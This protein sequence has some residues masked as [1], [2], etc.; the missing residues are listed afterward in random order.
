MRDYLVAQGAHKQPHSGRSLLVHLEGVH[1]IL[2]A[3]KSEPDVCRAGMFHSVYGTA[4]YKLQLLDRE[5]RAEVRD[6]IGARAEEVAWTFCKLP[7]RVQALD[8]S[9]QN[10]NHDWLAE[11]VKC[12]YS[13]YDQLW[14][15]LVRLECANLIEQH[16]L[17]Q[18]PSLGRHAQRIGMLD[19]E[20]FCV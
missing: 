8:L 19:A 18:F 4:A 12:R 2:V 20:G 6:L 3:A 10:C 9:L 17:H 16:A 11:Q 15:D 13:T 5:K 14:L 1:R 7:M